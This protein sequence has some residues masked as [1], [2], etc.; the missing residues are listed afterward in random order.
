MTIG[1]SAF[2]NCKSLKEIHFEK[3]TRVV[4]THVVSDDGCTDAILI[5]PDSIK[6]QYEECNPFFVCGK[7]KTP[8]EF[9]QYKLTLVK[10][11]ASIQSIIFLRKAYS[12]LGDSKEAKIIK[13]IIQAIQQMSMISDDQFEAVEMLIQKIERKKKTYEQ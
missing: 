1:F 13:Q 7:I 11:S 5:V 6:S 10:N 4:D 8:I 2:H 12:L 3:C 9:L